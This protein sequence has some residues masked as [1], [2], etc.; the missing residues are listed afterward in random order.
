MLQNLSLTKNTLNR[1]LKMYKTLFTFYTYFFD[2][3]GFIALFWVIA[4]NKLI[5]PVLNF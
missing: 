4:K 3:F 1:S 2:F 5:A